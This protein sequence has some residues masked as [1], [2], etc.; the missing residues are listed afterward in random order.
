MIINTIQ[1]RGKAF[2]T[3]SGGVDFDSRSAPAHR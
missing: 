3:K 2:I 1:F